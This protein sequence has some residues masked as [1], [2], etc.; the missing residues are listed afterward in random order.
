MCLSKQSQR[1]LLD[2]NCDAQITLADVSLLLSLV[3]RDDKVI[4]PY[5]SEVQATNKAQLGWK[6][7]KDEACRPLM[8]ICSLHGAAGDIVPCEI[9]IAHDQS[10]NRNLATLRNFMIHTCPWELASVCNPQ[11]WTALGN[12]FENQIDQKTL[13]GV[14]ASGHFMILS[15]AVDSVPLD[16]A[17][18][19]RFMAFSVASAPSLLTSAWLLTPTG[20]EY[21]D[22]M[23]A[24]E[25]QLLSNI[26][27]EDALNVYTS[28]SFGVSNEIKSLRIT[29]A[30]Q[31]YILL[32]DF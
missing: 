18:W 1:T 22:S 4:I 28:Y 25:F 21:D 30:Y 31:N 10:W 29:G 3:I 32:D 9:K 19:V 11:G 8:P 2:F 7:H 17:S 12:D 15:S 24:V 20:I 26:A 23:A 13:N 5:S 14:S 27:P 16:Q 6:P